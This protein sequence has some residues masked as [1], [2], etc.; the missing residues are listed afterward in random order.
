MELFYSSCVSAAAV[1]L[2]AAES[3]HCVRVLRHR[4]G[5][6][7]SVIDGQGTLLHC[8]LTV[9]DPSGAEAVVVS[10]EEGF[11]E[12]PYCLTMVVCPTKNIDRYEWFIEKATEFGLDTVVPVIGEHSER[13]VVKAE[14]IERILLSAAKQSL[15]A[16]VP[17]FAPLCSVKD[18]L[19]S[20][21]GPGGSFSEGISAGGSVFD[22]AGLSSYQRGPFGS[23]GP[24]T[25]QVAPPDSAQF[26]IEPRTPG[27]I[28]AGSFSEGIRSGSAGSFPEGFD[29][30]LI[31]CC[32]EPEGGRRS[33]A[34]LISELR[35][36]L[37]A[38]ASFGAPADKGHSPA[39]GAY[40]EG[41]AE[42]ESGH[43][44]SDC[45]TCPADSGSVAESAEKSAPRKPRIAVLIGPEGDFSEE[46]LSLALAQGWT[47]V[48]LGSSRLRTETA[49]LASV[50]AV[51]FGLGA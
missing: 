46:E 3:A 21:G 42:A 41:S 49:A 10:R 12:L 8:R 43:V 24:G 47:P 30:K 44:P 31:A 25:S 48:S 17:Q 7:I 28:S 6:E 40:P 14:R 51:Y 20:S 50:A 36:R 13:K 4:V 38:A 39:C 29:L 26:G 18:F 27:S 9:A 15:K 22:E 11:A 33:I 34:D 5:D 19:R 23:D 2:D 32:F 16:R 1:R 35:C 37:S 45:G